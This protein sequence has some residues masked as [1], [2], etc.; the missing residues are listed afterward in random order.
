M[1]PHLQK[2]QRRRIKKKLNNLIKEEIRKPL[3]KFVLQ[4]FFCY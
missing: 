2:L 3:A 1:L 4:E